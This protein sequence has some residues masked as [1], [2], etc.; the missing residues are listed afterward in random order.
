MVPA[1]TR[2]PLW[3]AQ[4]GDVREREAREER[5]G[6]GGG[7]G[8]EGAPRPGLFDYLAEGGYGRLEL[9]D[10]REFGRANMGQA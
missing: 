2:L 4:R 1:L 3:V 7:D 5:G 10:E 6:V 9:C 8:A